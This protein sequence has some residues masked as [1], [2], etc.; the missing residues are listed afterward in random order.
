MHE[1]SSGKRSHELHTVFSAMWRSNE[2]QPD[3][4]ES[5][6]W[7]GSSKS[8][9]PEKH[10]RPDKVDDGPS[11]AHLRWL[12]LAWAASNIDAAGFSL[13]LARLQL[14]TLG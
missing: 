3:D 7:R 13:A 10:D 4:D 1:V 9:K 14:S 12:A 5:E 8:D 6:S 2:Y 11:I